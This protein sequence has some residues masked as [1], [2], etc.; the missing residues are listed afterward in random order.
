MNVP[1]ESERESRITDKIVV[2]CD[3]EIE[4]AM[5]WYYYLDS[6]LQFPFE[7]EVISDIGIPLSGQTIKVISMAVESDCEDG[8]FVMIENSTSECILQ[9]ENLDT[10]AFG[11]KTSE[12]VE[13]WKYWVKRGH[14][15]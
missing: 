5:G 10:A 2:D 9:L 8:P 11:G 15:F 14:R 3:N 7:A 4:T 1:E 13:D 12:A 6:S